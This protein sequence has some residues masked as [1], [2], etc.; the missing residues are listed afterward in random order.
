MF[1][2]LRS[3]LCYCTSLRANPLAQS[4]GTSKTGFGQVGEKTDYCLGKFITTFVGRW[5]PKVQSKI[6]TSKDGQG[7][8]P[9]KSDLKSKLKFLAICPF[10]TTNISDM[11]QELQLLEGS[12][13]FP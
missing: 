11:V 6:Y 7:K 13:V 8:S 9:V 3:C 2:N 1:N 5:N 12:I 4:Q 10:W